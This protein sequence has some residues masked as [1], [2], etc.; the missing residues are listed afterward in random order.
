MWAAEGSSIRCASRTDLDQISQLS[1]ATRPARKGVR[2]AVGSDDVHVAML[3]L[4]LGLKKCNNCRKAAKRCDEG[5][6]CSRCVKLGLEESCRNA[7]TKLR[8]RVLK[9]SH[10]GAAQA[11]VHPQMAA[12]SSSSMSAFHGESFMSGRASALRSYIHLFR[13]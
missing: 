3:V 2:I 8:N 7:P 4:T 13:L 9:G 10:R 11:L 5:R 6:P 1:S 12:T